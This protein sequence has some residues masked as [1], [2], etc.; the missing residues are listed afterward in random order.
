MIDIST[1]SLIEL[2]EL[3]KQIDVEIVK[4][5]ETEKQNLRT[6]IQRMAANAGMTL[7]EI[8]SGLDKKPRKQAN[9]GIAQFRNP[10]DAEQTWTGRGRKPQWVLDWLASG[11][12]LDGL[13][14]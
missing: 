1:L 11:K 5:K 3:K 12:N 8:L 6:E 9:A 13:R 7:N 2:A 14:I 10:A 4:R